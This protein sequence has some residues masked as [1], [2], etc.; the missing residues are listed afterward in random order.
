MKKITMASAAILSATTLLTSCAS[1]NLAKSNRKA[2]YVASREMTN[3]SFVKMKDGSVLHYKTLELV[4]G[5]FT[6]PHLLADGN[7]RIFAADILAY[8]NQDHYA[9]SQ[10][11]FSS[12][13][14]SSIAVETLPGFAIRMTKGKL[15]IYCKKFYNGHAAVDEFFIQSNRDGQIYSYTPDLLKVMIQDNQ[16]AL[17][18]FN[19]SQPETEISKTLKATAE[20]YNNNMVVTSK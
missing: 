1:V 9:I 18:Y 12:G 17:A 16:Q 7:T 2:Q 20:I 8:Q 4:K 13:R 10:S 19:E 5:V 15:N 6:A 14:K 11:T 3:G